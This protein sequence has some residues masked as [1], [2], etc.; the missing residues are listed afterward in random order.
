MMR[1]H[2]KGVVL[3]VLALAVVGVLVHHHFKTRRSLLFTDGISKTSASERPAAATQAR[4][5]SRAKTPSS[6]P[7]AQKTPRSR[8][9]SSSQ[10]SPQQAQKRTTAV[11]PSRSEA[12]LG[13]AGQSASEKASLQSPGLKDPDAEAPRE[14]TPRDQ[15]ARE[16]AAAAAVQGSG[17]EVARDAAPG[18][19]VLQVSIE[20]GKTEESGDAAHKTDVKMDIRTIDPLSATEPMVIRQQEQLE[21]QERLG[22]KPWR[23][24]PKPPEKVQDPS[25]SWLTDMKYPQWYLESVTRSKVHGKEKEFVGGAPLFEGPCRDA[26]KVK[27][28]NLAEKVLTFSYIEPGQFIPGLKNPCWYE[29]PRKRKQMRCLPYFYVAGVAKCGTTDIFKRV[30]IHPAIMQGELKEYHWWDRLRYGAPME[31]K[32]TE[33]S[34]RNDRPLPLALY[35][36]IIMG[37][38]VEE[39]KQELRSRNHSDRICGDGSPSY[40]WDPRMWDVFEGNQGC[41]EPRIVIGSFIQHANPQSKIIL[42]F[43]HPTQRLY[44]RF[45][46][47][48]DSYRPFR[49][50]TTH[51]FHDYVVKGVALYKA[52]FQQHSIRACAYN[53]TLYD[54]AVIRLVEGMYSVFMEDWL[55]IFHR[56]QMLVL[57]NEDYSDDI[58]GHIL[59]VFNFLGAAKLGQS[60]MRPVLTHVSTN[61]GQ[62]YKKVGAMLP[63]TIAILNEF[64]KP[65]V[66]RLH[67]LLGGDD[68]FL[69]KD[70]AVT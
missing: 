20:V 68:R 17:K 54:E 52:C 55:R 21:E 56:E 59:R 44:S 48:R 36:R 25:Q 63:E 66:L 60:E 57:R 30:R 8:K 7:V 28:Q 27:A 32:F 49:G 43:R 24:R 35:S 67:E 16:T 23:G 37:D 51:T 29:D 65:F 39:M 34:E 58:E 19:E 18:A 26:D 61:I 46:S 69:W 9:V 64:Y 2:L 10:E 14:P 42:L 12:G 41:D 15:A 70:I 31:L 1:V 47:R 38:E 40:L 45:L 53:R 5:T 13:R 11:D 50:A 22:Y 4:T 62:N 6:G 33:D 3:G